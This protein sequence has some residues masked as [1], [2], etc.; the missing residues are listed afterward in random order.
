MKPNNL[1]EWC[2]VNNK[3]HIIDEWSEE[4]EKQPYDFTYGSRQKV[5]WICP[6]GHL[7]EQLII[8]R[9][10]RN[11]NC[12]YC[13]GHAVLEGY[14]DLKTLYPELA[15]EWHPTKNKKTQSE[16]TTGSGKRVWWLCPKGHEYQAVI[17]DRTNGTNCPECNLR[18]QTSFPEQAI[19]YY[20]KKIYPDAIS[21]YKDIFKNTMELDIFIPSIMLGIEYDGKNW[22]DSEKEYEREKKKYKIC[23][24]KAIKLIRFR[25]KNEWPKRIDNADSIYY[26]EKP[27][28][29]KYL[30]Q[31]IQDFINRIQ[32]SILPS[33][34]KVV[35]DLERDKE[36]I[37]SYLTSID[38]S[39]A[40]KRPDVVKM[41][42]YEENGSLKPEMFSVSSN[43]IINWKCPECGHKWKSSINS[44]TRKGR[45]GCA[46]C[47]KARKGKS[48]TK[49]RV[50]ERGSL[51]ENNPEL[52]KEW[53]PIKNGDLKP[54][55]VTVGRFKPVWW[56]C[57]TCGYEWQQSPNIRKR[58]TGCPHCSGRVPMP[59]VDDLETVKP[60]LAKEWDYEKNKKKPTEYLP[61]SGKKV[62]W[63][64]SRCNNSWEEIIRNRSNGSKCPVCK[65]K[66]KDRF[67]NRIFY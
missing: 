55:D 52:A 49:R 28:D 45:N 58:G 30:A 14:N 43:E 51:A 46:E 61:K 12:P 60:E 26:I 44:M 10:K 42:D 37:L 16:F 57:S 36:E 54:E 23:K 53:H 5:K 13:S 21:K 27:K 41:W 48:F 19:Y 31:I 64:C 59:G 24:E 66:E 40:N 65:Q 35:V 25:E 67:L 62:W 2:R 15:K 38:N 11:Y 3:E 7:Y 56:L 8:K 20:V 18:K 50:K 29:R 4:N 47:G 32:F 22:H 34:S 6:K 9:T 17:K 1:I 63:R 33:M 39:L